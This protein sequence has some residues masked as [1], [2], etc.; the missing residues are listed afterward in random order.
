MPK[1][2]YD[3]VIE[4]EERVVPYNENNSSNDPNKIKTLPNGHKVI[5]PQLI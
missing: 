4:V 5:I 2:L 1:V 3:D